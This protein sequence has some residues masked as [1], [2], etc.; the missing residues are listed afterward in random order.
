MRYVAAPLS[1]GP[2]CSLHNHTGIVAITFETHRHAAAERRCR[3]SALVAS[4]ANVEADPLSLLMRTRPPWGQQY[5]AL[6]FLQVLIGNLGG[7]SGYPG[8]E[9]T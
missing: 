7:E 2:N 6:C 3:H 9:L 5:V 4:A 1:L 8:I